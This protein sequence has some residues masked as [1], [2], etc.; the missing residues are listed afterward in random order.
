MVRR[1]SVAS[2]GISKHNQER[3]NTDKFSGSYTRD[4]N[5]LERRVNEARVAQFI[6]WGLSQ[7][8]QPE[9]SLRRSTAFSSPEQAN[10]THREPIDISVEQGGEPNIIDEENAQGQPI[11]PEESPENFQPTNFSN[12][13]HLTYLSSSHTAPHVQESDSDDESE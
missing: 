11:S 3:R 8:S 2:T 7:E 4:V 10:V 5:P 9:N 12:P 6:T 1:V 13:S